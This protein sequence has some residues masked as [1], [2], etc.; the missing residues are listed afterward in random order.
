MNID[1][2]LILFLLLK[3]IIGIRFKTYSTQFY[4]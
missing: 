2:M 1:K 4:S 3:L